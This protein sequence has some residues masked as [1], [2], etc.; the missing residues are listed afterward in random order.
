MST[1]CPKLGVVGKTHQVVRVEENAGRTEAVVWSE[2][3]A[4]C[5]KATATASDSTSTTAISMA[6]ANLD[7][8]VEGNTESVS[9]EPW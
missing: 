5:L 8:R 2:E 4:G 3:N 6:I 9:W 7:H 1:W